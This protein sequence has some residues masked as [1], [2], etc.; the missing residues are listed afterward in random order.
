MGYTVCVKVGEPIYCYPVQAGRGYT[1]PEYSVAY[2]IE[3]P[4]QGLIA[5]VEYKALKVVSGVGYTV[6]VKVGEPIYCYP[7][8]AGRDI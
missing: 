5:Y 3:Y 7:V 6:C 1:F 2:S 4:L 8:Q